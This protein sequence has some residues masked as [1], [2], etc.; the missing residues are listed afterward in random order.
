[1]SRRILWPSISS[2]CCD[3]HEYYL[4]KL[5]RSV[6]CGKVEQ[7][8]TNLGRRLCLQ[9][10]WFSLQQTVMRLA[11]LTLGQRGAGPVVTIHKPAST[12]IDA[13]GQPYKLSICC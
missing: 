11:S 8:T 3:C 13:S 9:I 6:T 2:I 4:V 10:G 12:R 5:G 7:Q 1:M